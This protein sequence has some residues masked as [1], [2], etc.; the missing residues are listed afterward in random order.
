MRSGAGVGGGGSVKLPIRPLSLHT[1]VFSTFQRPC[2]PVLPNS[3]S[4]NGKH[5]V[6]SF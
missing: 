4:L 2:T 5:P 1:H 3:P 6:P